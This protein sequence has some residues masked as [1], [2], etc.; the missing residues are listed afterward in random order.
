MCR[1]SPVLLLPSRRAVHLT[2]GPPFF[3]ACDYSEMDGV[4]IGTGTMPGGNYYPYNLGDTATHEVR[5]PIIL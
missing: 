2:R 5:Q 3:R 4:V 1:L